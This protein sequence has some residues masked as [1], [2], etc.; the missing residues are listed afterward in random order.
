LL[1]YWMCHK[2]VPNI[3]ADSSTITPL[4]PYCIQPKLSV[5]I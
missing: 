3:G 1:F 5:L 4:S 2:W